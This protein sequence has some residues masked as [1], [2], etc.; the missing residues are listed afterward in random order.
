LDTATL[1]TIVFV[2]TTN[3]AAVQIMST[4]INYQL[5]STTTVPVSMSFTLTK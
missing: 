1:Q 2:A 4:T 3:T 5:D